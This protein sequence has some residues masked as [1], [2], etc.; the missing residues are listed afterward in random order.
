LLNKHIY[1]HFTGVIV[2]IL[3]FYAFKNQK[4][5]QRFRKMLWQCIVLYV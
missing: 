4:K 5:L 1:S 2:V 3:N